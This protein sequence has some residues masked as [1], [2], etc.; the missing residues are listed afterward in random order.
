MLVAGRHFLE[1]LA[2]QEG[3][4]KARFEAHGLEVALDPRGLGARGG[5]AEVFCRHIAEAL[6]VIPEGSGGDS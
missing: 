2:G 1:D 3:S 5:I 6:D 4:W